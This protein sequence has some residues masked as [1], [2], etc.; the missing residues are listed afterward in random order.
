LRFAVQPSGQAQQ[1]QQQQQ[2]QQERTLRVLVPTWMSDEP[3]VDAIEQTAHNWEAITI[4][5]SDISAILKEKLQL[6]FKD[7]RQSQDA[8]FAK[9]VQSLRALQTAST[10]APLSTIDPVKYVS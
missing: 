9:A 2:Q 6:D 10:N 8:I 4:Q 7:S 5:M 3:H 1:Q